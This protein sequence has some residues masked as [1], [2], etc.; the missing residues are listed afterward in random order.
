MS[1][2]RR[3]GRDQWINARMK[4][5]LSEDY[6]PAC[7]KHNVLHND[8]NCTMRYTKQETEVAP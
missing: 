4:K 6:C 7:G 8:K 2:D 5:L 3:T 1:T